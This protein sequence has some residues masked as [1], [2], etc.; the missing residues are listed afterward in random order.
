MFQGSCFSRRLAPRAQN[1]PVVA[2][3][4]DESVPG[5]DGSAHGARQHLICRADT[6][7]EPHAHVGLVIVQVVEVEVAEVVDGVI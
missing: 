2:A 7:G 6:A 3:Q 5:A 1:T 4:H